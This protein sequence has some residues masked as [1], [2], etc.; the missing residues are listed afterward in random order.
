M[1][2]TCSPTSSWLQGIFVKKQGASPCLQLL[3][4]IISEARAAP[5]SHSNP[6]PP[7]SAPKAPAEDALPATSSAQPAV[8]SQPQQNGSQHVHAKAPVLGDGGGPL[9]AHAEVKGQPPPGDIAGD[10]VLTT[11]AE[12]PAAEIDMAEAEAGPTVAGPAMPAGWIAED[13][14]VSA[15]L[16]DAGPEEGVPPGTHAAED[17]VR[18]EDDSAARPHRPAVGP[19]RPP[20]EL[21]AA[22]AEVH[23]A[24]RH[25][26]SRCYPTCYMWKS[27]C[28]QVC[29]TGSAPQGASSLQVIGTHITA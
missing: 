21:L 5:I 28:L 4:P 2:A 8:R 17:A 27:A 23:Q 9:S 26:S 29:L 22:A 16:D 13:V 6:A 1:F 11:T 14:P 24:V 3:G 18:E 10:E 25:P 20:P 7:A 19:A 12:H 15:E